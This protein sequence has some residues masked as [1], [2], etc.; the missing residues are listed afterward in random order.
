ML[1]YKRKRNTFFLYFC[2]LSANTKMFLIDNRF[3]IVNKLASGSG[4]GG[5]RPKVNAGEHV[6]PSGIANVRH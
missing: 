1:Q 6:C 3:G 5:D 2:D 4:T